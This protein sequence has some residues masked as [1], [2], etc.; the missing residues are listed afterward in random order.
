MDRDILIY[1]GKKIKKL[2]KDINISQE[3]LANRCE[4]H[5]TYIGMIEHGE[6]I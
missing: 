5:R 1:F 4:L 6:K 3:E 2:R